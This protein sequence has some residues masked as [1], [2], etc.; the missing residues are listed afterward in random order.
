MLR[1]PPL[2]L[3]D[4][5]ETGEQ[6]GFPR[7]TH[8]EKGKHKEKFSDNRTITNQSKRADRNPPTTRK[9]AHRPLD[10]NLGQAHATAQNTHNYTHSLTQDT[11][12][13]GTCSTHTR[14]NTTQPSDMRQMATHTPQKTQDTAGFRLRGCCV[15]PLPS[16]GSFSARSAVVRAV[17]CSPLLQGTFVGV[18]TGDLADCASM[19]DR[20]PLGC[21]GGGEYPSRPTRRGYSAARQYPQ[22]NGTRVAMDWWCRIALKCA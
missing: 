6:W 5:S 7:K 9:Q 19:G 13:K 14:T 2:G 17:Q 12:C 10:M 22:G 20:R 21:S 8:F 1:Y 11:R 16:S 15:P 18:P 4:L 3:W